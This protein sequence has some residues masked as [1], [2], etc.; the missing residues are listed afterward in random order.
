M[1][2][3][4]VCRTLYFCFASCTV[5][6]KY[7]HKS[8]DRD[9]WFILPN[10]NSIQQK[11]MTSELTTGEN[12]RALSLFAGDSF[13]ADFVHYYFIHSIYFNFKLSYLEQCQFNF[14]PHIVFQCHPQIKQLCKRN[15][16]NLVKT[17][18]CC[19]LQMKSFL[20]WMRITFLIVTSKGAQRQPTKCDHQ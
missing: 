17:A 8:I 20:A 11:A 4:V 13:D 14:V 7:D 19:V 18:G 15:S 1:C 9:I 12:S 10:Q 6:R 2:L 5:W 3:Y 16:Y